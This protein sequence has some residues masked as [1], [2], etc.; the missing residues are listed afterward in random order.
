MRNMHATEFYRTALRPLA[1][2][3]S[4]QRCV[5]DLGKVIRESA[6]K[7]GFT[8]LKEKQTEAVLSFLKGRDTFVALPT[9]Y[10]KSIIYAILPYAFD[11]I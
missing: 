3:A 6:G 9:G 4:L 7:L 10:G 5:M 1:L 2:S 8:S 11:S